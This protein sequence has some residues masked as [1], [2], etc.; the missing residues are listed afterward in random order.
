MSRG[1][2]GKKFY[3]LSDYLNHLKEHE[4][5]NEIIK[6][7][8]K[9]CSK[10]V[11]NAESLYSHVFNCFENIAYYQ[12]VYCSFGGQTKDIMHTHLSN[13][14]PSKMSLVYARTDSQP[15]SVNVS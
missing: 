13:L 7:K 11:D 12:C 5:N 9:K 15:I 1:V 6:A 4:R 8:C 14:H 2:T 3:V 10:L